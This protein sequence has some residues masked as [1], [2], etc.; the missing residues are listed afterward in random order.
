MENA[1]ENY[2]YSMV[3]L[4]RNQKSRHFTF[5]QIHA[6]RGE[7]MVKFTG[8]L[9]D[10]TVPAKPARIRKKS[11]PPVNLICQAKIAELTDFLFAG[12]PS[13]T[14]FKSCSKGCIIDRSDSS[15]NYQKGV[16]ELGSTIYRMFD[17]STIFTERLTMVCPGECE[18]CFGTM[19]F[20]VTD[21]GKKKN[22]EC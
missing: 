11:N 8:A 17:A 15:L 9:R 22:L 5:D 6:K 13:I 14:G 12:T 2:V 20:T 19:K 16:I 1:S 10:T 7:A 21:I 18:E 3:A 4:T